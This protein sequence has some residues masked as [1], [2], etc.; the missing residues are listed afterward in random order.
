MVAVDLGF[1]VE[2]GENGA[3][4]QFGEYGIVLCVCGVR[5]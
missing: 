4:K 1:A 3:K 5:D 2:K